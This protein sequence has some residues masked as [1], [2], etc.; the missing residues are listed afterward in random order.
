MWKIRLSAL[1]LVSLGFL[2]AIVV[3]QTEVNPSSKY[4]FKLGLDLD[5]GTH[6]KYVADTSQVSGDVDGAMESLRQTVERR[7]NIFGVSEPIVQVEKASFLSEADNI[8]FDRFV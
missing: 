1:L 7:V 5:G 4:N 8:H 6:L 3:Y 2:L